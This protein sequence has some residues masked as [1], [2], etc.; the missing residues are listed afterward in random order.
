MKRGSISREIQ[1]LIG[2]VKIIQKV[3]MEIQGDDKV[4]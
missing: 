1:Q 3:L 2:N 4:S